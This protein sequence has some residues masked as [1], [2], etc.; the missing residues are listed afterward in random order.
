MS[1][2]FS[3]YLQSTSSPDVTDKMCLEQSQCG[4][5]CVVVKDQHGCPICSC[6]DRSLHDVTNAI[7]SIN[8]GVV[9][10]EE[11][12]NDTNDGGIICPELKCDLHCER[13]LIMDEND[14]T[15]CE[16]KPH[17]IRCSPMLGCKKKCPYGYKFNRRGCP[18]VILFIE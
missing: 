3:F 11:D 10:P 1:C 6:P 9:V 17:T 5:N 15:L 13:G 4:R 7:S 18:V 16:C 8:G 12:E 14:C 2:F